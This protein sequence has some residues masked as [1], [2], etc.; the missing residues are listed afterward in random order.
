MAGFWPEWWE[1]RKAVIGASQRWW[2][3]VVYQVMSRF[4][5]ETEADMD[6]ERFWLS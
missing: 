6:I 2:A 1:Y 5:A 3:E 4:K